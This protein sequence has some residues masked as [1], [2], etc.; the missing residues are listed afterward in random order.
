MSRTASVSFR[1]RG[2]WAYDVSLSVL[3]AE[4]INIISELGLA[5]RSRWLSELLPELR[6]HAV[7]GAN[8]HLDLDLGLSDPEREHLLVL[9]AKASQRLR[10]RETITAAEAAAW[11]VLDGR[12][13][14]WRSAPAVAAND[15]ADL[16]DAIIGLV[17]GTL[18]TAPDGTWW[19]FG[20]PG[21]PRTIKMDSKPASGC[22]PAKPGSSYCRTRT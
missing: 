11:E 10:E 6:R 9:I 16:G 4:L 5:K 13:V 3:L 21:D 2:L 15:I 12:T 20:L 14:I 19:L 22:V 8:A 17:R 7:L 18:S 1:Q